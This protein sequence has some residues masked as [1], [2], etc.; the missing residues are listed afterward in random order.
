MESYLTPTA[1]DKLPVAPHHPSATWSLDARL[2]AT[3]WRNPNARGIAEPDP[4]TLAHGERPRRALRSPCPH[5][6]RRV[7]CEREVEAQLNQVARLD[8]ALMR[9]AAVWPDPERPRALA[10]ALHEAHA[11]R[12]WV[13]DDPTYAGRSYERRS[14][15]YLPRRASADA[16][17]LRAA[18]RAAV[19]FIRFA[20]R[21]L[22]R[23][24][25]ERM[26]S[27]LAGLRPPPPGR[28]DRSLRTLTGEK[29]IRS[30]AKVVAASGEWKSV[31]ARIEARHFGDAAPATT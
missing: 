1:Q 13:M 4:R 14:R 8:A 9:L 29:D 17:R 24:R 11:G 31:A 28:D 6:K 15:L 23:E 19:V 16:A 25:D 12:V 2:A 3:W 27:L 20:E 30:E 7:R 22:A 5:S 26:R 10:R 18:H 21:Q